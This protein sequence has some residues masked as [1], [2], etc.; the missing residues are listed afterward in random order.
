[1]KIQIFIHS[2]FVIT[3]GDFEWKDGTAVDYSNWA[4]TEPDGDDVDN[5]CVDMFPDQYGKW[6]DSDCQSNAAYVCMTP[7]GKSMFIHMF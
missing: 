4:N 2:A 3:T 6:E 1:M 7:K 5:G